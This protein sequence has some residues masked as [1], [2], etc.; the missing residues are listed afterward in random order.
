MRRLS[1]FYTLTDLHI[2]QADGLLEGS[3]PVRR[4]LPTPS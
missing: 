4:R 1:S 2:E 3:M